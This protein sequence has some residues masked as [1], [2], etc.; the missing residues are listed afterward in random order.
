MAS[1]WDDLLERTDLRPWPVPARRWS[2]TMCWRDLL[3]MHWRLP[4]ELIAAL[5]PPEL[6]L[7]TFDGA[8]WIG[9]VPFRMTDV[10]LR[11]LGRMPWV[12]S[13]AELNV[14]TYVKGGGK[15]GV[16]FFSLDAASRIAVRVARAR[17]HLP[18]FDARMRCVAKPGPDRAEVEGGALLKTFETFLR[19]LDA[20]RVRLARLDEVAAGVMAAGD[21]L[22]VARVVRGWIEGRSNWIALQGRPPE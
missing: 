15:A 9:V 12:S 17:F 7:D 21:D 4:P 19:E 11:H 6:E 8:A 18:Y 10:G 16:W 1:R 14:R 5:V 2:I 22:P 3:F 13:F 20:S